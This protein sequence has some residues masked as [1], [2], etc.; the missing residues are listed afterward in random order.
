MNIFKIGECSNFDLN[1]CALEWIILILRSHHF[2]SW[3][4][5]KKNDDILKV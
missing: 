3:K 2:V 4:Y 1:F 5:N